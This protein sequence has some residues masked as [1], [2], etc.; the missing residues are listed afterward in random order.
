M[1]SS[2]ENTCHLCEYLV[3][4]LEDMLN[5]SEPEI[6]KALVKSCEKLPGEYRQMCDTVVLLYGHQIIEYILKKED[7]KTLCH[8]LGLCKEKKVE[9]FKGETSCELCKYVVTIAESWLTSNKTEKEIETELHHICAKLPSSFTEEC[10]KLVDEFLPYI[11]YYLKQKYPAEKICSL[12]GLCKEEKVNE[13]EVKCFICTKVVDWVEKYVEKNKTEQEIIKELNQLCD[14]APFGQK[15]TCKSI[16]RE[17]LP[18]IIHFLEQKYPAKK[19][20]Q[21]LKMCSETSKQIP[22]PNPEDKLEKCP[23]CMIVINAVE[24]LIGE[25]ASKKDIEDALKKVCN[26][27][28]PKL[29]QTCDVMVKDFAIPIIESVIKRAT[30]STICKLIRLCPENS[31]T[32]MKIH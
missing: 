29:K 8:Q 32:Q 30:P 18:Y 2:N 20:C 12:I 26:R 4:N 11:F 24:S 28:N 27:V 21:I 9:E 23:T 13:G 19:I 31:K 17:Y 5:K 7:P 22:N 10:D 1:K 6:E 14:Y 25:A 15:D 3:F 16:V